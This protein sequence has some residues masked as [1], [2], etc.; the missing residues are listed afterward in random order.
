[1]LLFAVFTLHFAIL[2]LGRIAWRRLPLNGKLSDTLYVFWS[3]V[4]VTPTPV[5]LGVVGFW[6][7]I[8]FY[9]RN[10]EEAKSVISWIAK[11]PSAFVISGFFTA[12]L[13]YWVSQ[14]LLP[15]KFAQI[16]ESA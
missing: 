6:L 14:R 7:P 9:Y 12:I 4:F 15:F 13:A 16:G 5:D 1:M 10:L 2:W 3:V 8:A 11:D